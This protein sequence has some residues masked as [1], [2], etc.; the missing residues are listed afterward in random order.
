MASRETFRP[1]EEPSPEFL[2]SGSLGSQL[3]KCEYLLEKNGLIPSF[4]KFPT[5]VKKLS[6]SLF[7]R[8]RIK[9]VRKPQKT[10]QILLMAWETRYGIP[11]IP[12]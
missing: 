8:C 5:A 7:Y 6:L 2:T 1:P 9:I 10:Y 3:R 11:A 12:R 4:K